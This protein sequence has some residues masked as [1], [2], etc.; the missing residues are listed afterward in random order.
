LAV[1]LKV[2]SDLVRGGKLK[3]FQVNETGEEN[4]KNGNG[5]QVKSI[6]QLMKSGPRFEKQ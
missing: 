1:G 2:Y 6:S 4:R 3:G 5:D